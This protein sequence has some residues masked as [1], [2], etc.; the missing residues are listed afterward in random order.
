MSSIDQDAKTRI[1]FQI[2]IGLIEAA[3]GGYPIHGQFGLSDELFA[4]IAKLN[5]NELLQIAGSGIY[6]LELNERSLNIVT[7]NALNSRNHDRVIEDALKLGASRDLM[8]RY[9]KMPGEIFRKRRTQLNIGNDDRTRPRKLSGDE[10][11]R[12]ADL[13]N[14]YVKTTPVNSGE[15]H[16]RCLIYLSEH[17]GIDLNRIDS[18]YYLEN[19]NS[20]KSYAAVATGGGKA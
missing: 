4:R 5:V 19:I 9:L 14:L 15:D 7:Q 17:T 11:D 10:Y 8:K 16:L 18:Y 13:H 20:V 12:L 2:L 1:G 6:K 3:R